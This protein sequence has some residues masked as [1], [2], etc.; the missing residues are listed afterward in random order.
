MALQSRAIQYNAMLYTFYVSLF[1]YCNVL[2]CVRIN[3]DD[4]D[5]D[6]GHAASVNVRIQ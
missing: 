1:M 6:D 4:D 3:D 5:D 2:P